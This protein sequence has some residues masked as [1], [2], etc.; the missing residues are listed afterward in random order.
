MA[1][2]LPLRGATSVA[3][4]RTVTTVTLWWITSRSGTR[5]EG[6]RQAAVPSRHVLHAMPTD[7]IARTPLLSP[8]AALR[9]LRGGAQGETRPGQPPGR[10]SPWMGGRTS[11]ISGHAALHSLRPLT[12]QSVLC[13][14]RA[15][16]QEPSLPAR[17]RHFPQGAP[18][19]FP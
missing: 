14:G 11:P 19:P 18:A 2:R 17:G 10:L 15:M 9:Y 16:R 6:P 3:R 1:Y 12:A 5:P 8:P 7:A 4:L 13:L